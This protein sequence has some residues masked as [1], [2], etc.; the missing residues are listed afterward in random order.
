M[1]DS[2]IIIQL[3]LD[4]CLIVYIIIQN[5]WIRNLKQNDKYNYDNI[6]ALI[7]SQFYYAREYASRLWIDNPESYELKKDNELYKYLIKHSATGE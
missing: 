2:F 5:K 1:T 4:L 3:I 7:D 6:Q